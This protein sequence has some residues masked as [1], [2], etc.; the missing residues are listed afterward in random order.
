M[1]RKILKRIMSI[2]LA[3]SM[4]LPNFGYISVNASEMENSQVMNEQNL[5][6]DIDNEA[7]NKDKE[8]QEIN[9]LSQNSI[10]KDFEDVERELDLEQNSNNDKNNNNTQNLDLE[11]IKKSENNE[12]KDVVDEVIKDNIEKDDIKKDDVEKDKDNVIP[13]E[14]NNYNGISITTSGGESVSCDVIQIDN[15]KISELTKLKEYDKAPGH[16]IWAKDIVADVD[17]T[18]S[19]SITL[20]EKP[21]GKITVVHYKDGVTPEYIKHQQAENVITFELS[22]FSPVVV[23]EMNDLDSNSGDSINAWIEEALD[24]NIE[25]IFDKSEEWWNNLLPNQR[26]VAEILALPIEEDNS[27]YNTQTLDEVIEIIE[28][29]EVDSEKFFADTLFEKITLEQLY[30]LKEM[31][32]ELD[33]LADAILGLKEYDGHE[34][35]EDEAI[36]ELAAYVSGYSPISTFAFEPVTGDKVAYMSL[37]STGYTDGCGNTFW[38]IRNNGKYVYCM[39]H[40]SSLRSSYAY[41]NER[42]KTGDAAWLIQNY[43]QSTS[44]AEGYMCYQMAVWALLAGE[45]SSQVYT[46]AYSWY[47]KGGVPASS[48]AAWAQTTKTFFDMAKGKSGS[49]KVL[50]G[51]AGSQNVGTGST[52]LY[53][54]Y[55]PGTVP[56]EGGGGEEPPVIVYPEPEYAEYSDSVST[57]YKVK[58]NKSAVI[59]NEKLQGAKFKITESGT[60]NSKTATSDANGNLS[61]TFTHSDS[62]SVTY[63]SNIDEIEFPENEVSYEDAVAEVESKKEAFESISYTYTIDEIDVP[64]GFVKNT[65]IST[66]FPVRTGSIGDGGSD[67][68]NVTNKPW[69]AIVEIDKIDS[70]TNNRIAYDTA[71]DIYEYD[72]TKG[73]YSKSSNYTVVRLADNLTI[74]NDAET[75]TLEKGMYTVQPKYNDGKTGYLYYTQKNQGK[76]YIQETVAPYNNDINGYYG[77]FA[78]LKDNVGSDKNVHYIT[79]TKDYQHFYLNDK[80]TTGTTDSDFIN[81]RTLGQITLY[82][83]DTEAERYVDGSVRLGTAIETS[84]ARGDDTLSTYPQLDDLLAGHD[85]GD[86]DLDGAIYDLYA[87]EDIHHP[88]GVFGIAEYETTVYENGSWI[89]KTVKLEKDA[90]VASAEIKDG[91]LVYDNLYL[92][93][94][95]IKE[96]IKE[97]T[98]IQSTDLNGAVNT[99]TRKLSY[100]EGYMVDEAVYEVT[101]PYNNETIRIEKNFD[102][103]SDEQIVKGGFQLTKL[104]SQTGQTEQDVLEG[105]GF[106][107]YLISELS[108]ADEFSVDENGKY[109]LN[110]IL[111]AYINKEYNNETKK[112]DFS[113]ETAAIAKTYEN[114][115]QEI[116]DYNA[117]LESGVNG[118]GDGW[119]ATGA[120]HEYQ[121]S[122]LF[123]NKLG[124]IKSPLLP[125]GQYLVVETTEINNYFVVDPFIVDINEKS[126]TIDRQNMRYQLDEEFEAFLQI[127]K[128]D[129]DTGKPVLLAN[130][131]WKI[132]DIEKEEYVTMTNGYGAGTLQKTDIFYTNENGYLI[133][134]EVLTVGKYR[135]E[136]VDGPNGFY[137]EYATTKGTFEEAGAVYFEVTTN[138]IY[139]ATGDTMHNDRDVIAIYEDYSN[140]E[141][142]GALTIKKIGEVLTDITETMY[143]GGPIGPEIDPDLEFSKDPI[144]EGGHIPEIDPDINFVYETRPLADAVFEIYAAEDIYTQDRQVDEN[145][146][147]TTWFKS[148]ELVATVTTGEEGQ[149]DQYRVT[150]ANYPDGHPIVVESHVGN[151]GETQI[152]L[153]LGSY[154]VIEKQAP[155]GYVHSEQEFTVTFTWDN[156][157]EEIVFNTNAE[158]ANEEHNIVFEN[159]RVKPVPSEKDVDEESPRIG[160]GVFKLDS[161]TEEPIEGTMFKLYTKHDIYDIDGN[162]LIEAGS[163]LDT[164][165]TDENGL[166]YFDVDAPYMSEHY[167]QN[168]EG[169][170][171]PYENQN[172]G[173][174]IIIEE[175]VTDG[176][177]LDTTPMEVKF[178]YIDQYT[179]YIVVN[180]TQKNTKTTVE[181][182]KKDIT[183][184]EEIVGAKLQIIHKDTNEVVEE[185][186]SDG[187]PHVIRGLFLS[188]DTRQFENVYIL[189]ETLPANG[190]V[191]ASDVEFKLYQSKDDNDNWINKN[192]VYV[193]TVTESDYQAGTIISQNVFSDSADEM[194]ETVDAYVVAEW[195][196]VNNVLTI[197][198]TDNA[199]EEV[200]EKTI[201]E[202]DFS[203][204]TFDKVYFVNGTAEEF[205][206]ELVVTEK[207]ENSDVESS[208][209]WINVN[210]IADEEAYKVYSQE[211]KGEFLYEYSDGAIE[212]KGMSYSEMEEAL[213]ATYTLPEIMEFHNAWTKYLSDNEDAIS[214]DYCEWLKDYDGI[215][216]VLVTMYDDITK[217]NINKYD[218]TTSE[219]VI[220][221]TIQIVDKDG[222]VVE[223]WVSTEET[224]YIERLPIGEYELVEKQAPT[225]DG[226][227]KTETV[228]FTVDDTGSI[229]SVYMPDDYTKLQ[230]TKTDI[231]TGEPVIG[232]ELTLV[233]HK[234]TENGIED[235]EIAKWIT[236]EEP[237]YIERIP[238]GKYTLTETLTP[239]E[240]GYV[241]AESVD[242][243][244][245]ETYKIQV[246]DMDDDFTKVEIT[247]MEPVLKEALP[248][249]KLQLA[250]SNGVIIDTWTSTNKS[251]RIERLPVG[252]YILTELEAPEGYKIA[253]PLTVEIK[254][255][256]DVQA[257]VLNNEMIADYISLLVNKKV[258]KKETKPGDTLTY[259]VD[260]IYNK[261]ACA[262]DDFTL[263]DTMPEKVQL[264]TISLPTFNQDGT[265]DLYYKTNVSEKA[266]LEAANAVDKEVVKAAEEEIKKLN[267][268]KETIEDSII[269]LEKTIDEKE[270]KLEELQKIVDSAENVDE[271]IVEEF[272]SLT[273]ELMKL[274]E[275][276]TDAAKNLEVVKEKIAEQEIIIHPV[277]EWILWK[278]D[279][280]TK[281]SETLKVEDLK[282][283]KGEFIKEFKMEFGTVQSRFKNVTNLV[284]TGIV[285]SNLSRGEKLVNTV[286]LSGMKHTLR[287][288]DDASVSTVYPKLKP[289]KPS[290]DPKDEPTDKPTN[291]PAKTPEQTVTNGSNKP[292][293][294]TSLIEVYLLTAVIGT[295]IMV[296]VLKKKKED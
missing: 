16:A 268:E 98:N 174:Y 172:S 130:T 213:E 188:D 39:N 190:F 30:K 143:D 182:S 226:Y 45:T 194:P 83:I 46:Y 117:T 85:H 154:R 104:G 254:D 87:A 284:Y 196:C 71:F 165:T 156:Q 29:G 99:E 187:E 7:N 133:M 20:D 102:T 216:P 294:D 229:Q 79:L 22:S 249:A 167:G 260:E 58:V 134:P 94:Y 253:E 137:N 56:P 201:R 115:V 55:N 118:T 69:Q 274:N 185:W 247:K 101:L 1:K 173:E 128:I 291:E 282:L 296:M 91:K 17:E 70:E 72:K 126:P 31:G 81:Y 232:A 219:E 211:L 141:T 74:R 275:Q 113:S 43:G 217:I 240:D 251:H 212:S 90:L 97:T 147:R 80:E 19:V 18:V 146:N 163:Y 35:P 246:Q 195:L 255:T 205:Y 157:Y 111:N 183:N 170:D 191:T 82:K 48:A 222:N 140:R 52:I 36:L 242:F 10:T 63:C 116:S 231:A 66:Q 8:K 208:Y 124:V 77:D 148:G 287:Y 119:V 105:A 285:A 103:V 262:I 47:I 239:F 145:G 186:I 21:T 160:I 95:Y 227:V 210:D 206:E 24:G 270:V 276:L 122:E 192:E 131:S 28:S 12:K 2:V 267:K 272:N 176:Y 244:V 32:L 295:S 202:E 3:I 221:A 4:T 75:T 84:P 259:T 151:L 107:V 193:K 283:V 245:E 51:P 290:S 281:E 218:I 155:Y 142:R 26:K 112:Y 42:T 25:N 235:V 96:R 266:A 264:S 86:A 23:Y 110:S 78:K 223:E 243:E 248:G 288:T 225:E 135:L 139:Q 189:R 277:S 230:I 149:S 181:I 88:D 252:T 152:L 238:V 136:E 5:E 164:A 67:T 204:L 6:K 286:E 138:R 263:I 171:I 37:T 178:E 54:T 278:E 180:S 273:N 108:K 40:G 162:L 64:T 265:Y 250:D 150:Y 53:T 11:N 224:H 44:S 168:Y 215:S 203:D 179:P 60:G 109:D 175:M 280:S 92:G 125:Y 129:E 169:T 27:F 123:T 261:S 73:D 120:K 61:V 57:E 114:N 258:D 62:W 257:F 279:V 214:D 59:T 50:E 15:D 237:Y 14:K 38:I 228:K 106:T 76:F 100:A 207:P 293:G 41:G 158:T 198:F 233:Y 93:K 132:W 256:A 65:S 292:T 33:D 68:K 236:E 159:E 144:P 127:T 197:T 184:S 200:I 161:E 177:L 234:E 121:L 220:G 269:E 289:S 241:T 153:P 49:I 13:E 199:T 166:A 89:E 9:S 271:K 209:E 34:F